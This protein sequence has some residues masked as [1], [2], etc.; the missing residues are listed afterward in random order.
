[1]TIGDCGGKAGLPGVDNGRFT[2]DHVRVPRDNLLDRYGAIDAEGTYSSPIESDGRRF[3]T[4]LSTLVRGR[5]TV[6]AAAG[7]A[8]RNA[9]T[10]ATIYG[11][12]RRQF[13]GPDGQ[14]V[15]DPQR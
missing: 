7:S 4:M 2:F 13:A 8:T 15:G 11:L 6:G 5:I 9:L 10:L 1:M 3:F 14:D 12:H